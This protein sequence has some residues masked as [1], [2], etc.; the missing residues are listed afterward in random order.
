MQLRLRNDL[1]LYPWK[2]ALNGGE[3]WVIHDP[4]RNL[5][6][7]VSRWYVEILK[8]IENGTAADIA[9]QL[10]TET[11]FKTNED[12]V[13]EVA[14]FLKKNSLIITDQTK[15]VSRAPQSVSTFLSKLAKTYLFFRIP[16]VNPDR[17]LSSTLF[18]VKFLASRSFFWIT[19]IVGLCGIFISL[20]MWDDLQQHFFSLLHFGAAFAFVIALIYVKLL[21]ELAHAFV[22]KAYGVQVPVMG[23]AFLLLFPMPYTDT[24]Q[25]WKLSDRIFRRNIAAAGITSEMYLA[26]WSTFLWHFSPTPFLEDVLFITATTTWIS[27][28]LLNVVPFMRFDGYFILSDAIGIENLHARSGAMGRWYLRR[29]LWGWHA[30]APEDVAPKTQ[31]FLITFSYVVWVYRLFVFIAIALA[32]YHYVNPTVGIFLFVL[33]IY[34]LIAKPVFSE[35]SIWWKNR[36]RFKSSKNTKITLTVVLAGIVVFFVPF[37]MNKTI[38]GLYIPHQQSIAFAPENAVL[39]TINFDD[40]QHILTGQTVITLESDQLNND[41]AAQKMIAERLSA[42][43]QLSRLDDA[44]TIQSRGR[45]QGWKSA[46]Q[47]AKAIEN[48]LA[49]MTV[50]SPSDGILNL[51]HDLDEGDPVR[52]GDELFRVT[53]NGEA[54]I[55]A[56]VNEAL[57]N[58]LNIGDAIGFFAINQPWASHSAAVVAVGQKPTMNPQ[59]FALTLQG[60]GSLPTISDGN[61]PKF[62]EP[63]F[64]I[65]L[66]SD[67]KI[68]TSFDA[69]VSLHIPSARKSMAAAVF[70][71]AFALYHREFN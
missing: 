42:S 14:N 60:G 25:S 31:R 61:I 20:R 69:R 9:E 47:T 57:M 16:L 45:D 29:L 55:V 44:Q 30:S 39:K 49:K 7:R 38:E 12:Q 22:A 41:F 67:T 68:P 23:I 13:T 21:H 4:T 33:E 50:L 46:L 40:G 24:S 5:F 10:N 59:H 56:Y 17:A 3:Q 66:A 52:K 71:R 34:L 48:R 2:G 32:V 58:E 35:I 70:E 27:S 65:E 6:F 26:A 53:N 63:M 51:R 62:T 18:L 11:A 43:V 64:L 54:K 19:L 37:Q 1:E 28:L 8:R 36:D 15:A